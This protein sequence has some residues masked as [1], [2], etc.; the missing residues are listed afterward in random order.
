MHKVN[1]IDLFKTEIVNIPF[2]HFLSTSVLKRGIE[3]KLF[4]WFEKTDQWGFTET[5]FY[6]QYEFGILQCQ[7]PFE[8]QCLVDTETVEN[9]CDKL[10]QVYNITAFDLVGVTAHKLINEHKIG[11]HNDYLEH[12]ETHRLVIQIN[13]NWDSVKRRF[14]NAIQFIRCGRCFKNSYAHK[15]YCFWI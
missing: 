14:F 11:V 7:L 13:P 10:K 3:K 15:Q 5:D 2:R 12:E 8:L 9:I 4:D 6:T 1:C